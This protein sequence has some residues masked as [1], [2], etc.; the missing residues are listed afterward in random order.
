[1]GYKR[2]FLWVE[3][4]DDERFFDRIIKPMFQKKYDSVE[5]IRYARSKNE[6]VDRYLKSIR[7]MNAD[8]IYA[9]DINDLPCVTAKKQRIQQRIGNIDK[10]NIIVVIKEI[11]SWFLA[12]LSEEHMK[13]LEIHS[14]KNK[15]TDNVTKE[16]FN[17]LIP[18]AFDSRIDFMS[19][20]LKL[21]SIETARKR[22]VS[23]RYLFKRYVQ[24]PSE[25]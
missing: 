1:M 23:F 13:R 24:N 20:I 8:C 10:K 18:D 5:M 14:F 22:N 9:T 17:S 16:Q 25:V 7:A 19:E 11:E 21:F 15:T 3:G 4:S 6:K 2:L 12:G